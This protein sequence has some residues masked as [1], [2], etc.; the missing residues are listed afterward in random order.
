[1]SKVTQFYSNVGLAFR[2]M[3]RQSCQKKR[4]SL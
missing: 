4:P 3:Y 1:L 2:Y